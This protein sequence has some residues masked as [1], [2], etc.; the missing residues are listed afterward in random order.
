MGIFSRLFKRSTPNPADDRYFSPLGPKSDSGIRI[1]PETA[2]QSSVV[3]ACVKVLAESMASLPIF[4][5]KRNG[6]SREKDFKHPL[7]KVLHHKPNKWQTSF[8][9][10]EMLMGHILLRGNAYAEKEFDR[11]MNVVSLTPLDPSRM[12]VELQANGD[13]KYTYQKLDGTARLIPEDFLLHIKG[14]SN[15]GVKGFSVINSTPNPV[16]LALALEKHG[17][18]LFKNSANPGGLLKHPAKLSDVA[19][20]R[21]KDSWNEIHQGAQNSGKMAILEEGLEWVKVGMDNTDSQMLENR[22][23]QTEEICRMFRVP[24]HLIQDLSRS[25]FSNIEHQSIDFVQHTLLP[26]CKR[27]E[28]ALEIR[29]LEEEQLETHFIE[30]L[31]DGLLRG[32]FL[33]R[34]NGL[35]VQRNNGII[36]ANEWRALENMNPQE[37]DGGDVYLVQGAMIS[38]EKAKD[39]APSNAQPDGEPV[40]DEEPQAEDDTESDEARKVINASYSDIINDKFNHFN[41]RHLNFAK[42][43]AKGTAKKELDAYIDDSKEMIKR[44]LTP[45]VNSYINLVQLFTKPVKDDDKRTISDFIIDSKAVE[46]LNRLKDTFNDIIS[47]RSTADKAEQSFKTEE[48]LAYVESKLI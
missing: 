4:V 42:S 16:G 28:E 10:R 32:D 14:M 46:Y 47:N 19:H 15:D 37:G 48:L 11:K 36:N 12:K 45:I 44:E 18:S 23:F 13:V 6:S 35:A 9:F 31:L 24:P 39:A 43:L 27:W 8:E 1:T 40:K 22:K 38:L 29:L 33:T 21:L 17:A 41:R 26:W 25:T 30:F 34:Q 5:Y 20:K 2:L 3:Y 7:Y